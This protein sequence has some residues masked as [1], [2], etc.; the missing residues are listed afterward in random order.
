MIMNRRLTV[1]IAA[2]AGATLFLL[3][4]RLAYTIGVGLD[5]WQPLTRPAGV[6]RSAH[7]VS[8]SKESAWFDCWVDTPRNVDVCRAWDEEGR[9]IASGDFRLEDE[10]RAATASEL[11]PSMVNIGRDGRAYMIYLYG[12][13]NQIQ[14][15]ILL[16]V[17]NGRR[18]GVPMV[19]T[20][21]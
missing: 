15:R 18:I 2:A 6:P 5:L 16:P 20:N 19:T 7:Y 9:L 11:R 4:I 8:T 1:T 13:N 12:P 14:G 21:P 3:A 17:I 10:D